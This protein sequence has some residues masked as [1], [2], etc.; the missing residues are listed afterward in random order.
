MGSEP[1]GVLAKSALETAI[2]RIGHPSTI[3]GET[4][5]MFPTHLAVATLG[6]ATLGFAHAARYGSGVTT[7]V[8][9]LRSP[10]APVPEAS[11]TS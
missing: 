4:A 6:P 9:V 5:G 2:R 10:L 3:H 8:R 7:N 11:F 1:T